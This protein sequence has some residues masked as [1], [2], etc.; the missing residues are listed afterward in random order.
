MNA[1]DIQ[2]HMLATDVTAGPFAT[3]LTYAALGLQ[4]GL[5]EFLLEMV[6]DAG[7]KETQAEKLGDMLWYAS[8][9]GRILFLRADDIV[10]VVDKR[11]FR[12][13]LDLGDIVDSLDVL[14]I[15]ISRIS[16]HVKKHMRNHSLDVD[17]MRIYLACVYDISDELASLEFDGTLESVI[18]QNI[19]KLKQRH[20]K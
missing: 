10:R 12:D 13:V 6:G 8:R 9:I 20:P 4:G 19:E 11:D 15:T 5:G 16:E 14:Q 7:T 17:F 18:H 2:K 1:L 3:D